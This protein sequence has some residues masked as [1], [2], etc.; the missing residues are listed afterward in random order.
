L[1]GVSRSTVPRRDDDAHPHD[2]E[3]DECVVDG[4]D[5]VRFALNRIEI[6]C[7]YMYS[8]KFQV[9]VD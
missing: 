3:L 8:F 7:K 9:H 2:R 1:I 5:L 4:L 6:T